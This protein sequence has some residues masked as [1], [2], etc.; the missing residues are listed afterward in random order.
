M[1]RKK[2]LWLI[3][4]LVLFWPA[5]KIEAKE[6]VSYGIDVTTLPSEIQGYLSSLTLSENNG[7]WHL[8]INN[9]LVGTKN[10]GEMLVFSY[11]PD[12]KSS[13]TLAFSLPDQLSIAYALKSTHVKTSLFVL[14]MNE[15]VQAVTFYPDS[16]NTSVYTYKETRLSGGYYDF[17]GFTGDGMNYS[18]SI[19]ASN[20]IAYV[21]R[22]GSVQ[23]YSLT[24][25]GVM[26]M[27]FLETHVPAH[28]L[29]L[30]YMSKGLTMKSFPDAKNIPYSSAEIDQAI[31]NEKLTLVNSHSGLTFDTV[32][33]QFIT[34]WKRLGKEDYDT[35]TKETIQVVCQWNEDVCESVRQTYGAGG[36]LYAVFG[37]SYSYNTISSY[38]DVSLKKVETTLYKNV[39][40]PSSNWTNSYNWPDLGTYTAVRSSTSTRSWSDYS[41]YMET[42]LTYDCSQDSECEWTSK[43]LYR[44]RTGTW[45][46]YG[47]YS[48]G[49]PS[50]CDSSSEC[51][52][53][54]KEYTSKRTASLTNNYSDFVSSCSTTDSY[55]CNLYYKYTCKKNLISSNTA[56]SAIKYSTGV[57]GPC[58]S[59]YKISKVTEGYRYRYLNWSNWS[60][61]SAT[62][63]TPV[64]G[65]T[66]C[67]SQTRYATSYLSW[68]NWSDYNQTSCSASS[69]KQ[70]QSKTMYAYRYASWSEYSPWVLTTSKTANDANK[71]TIYQKNDGV[72]TYDDNKGTSATKGIGSYYTG[73]SEVK[74]VLQEVKDYYAKENVEK[75]GLKP[76][77]NENSITA[78]GNMI[79]ENSRSSI[80]YKN[81][82]SLNG[83][84]LFEDVETFRNSFP[85]KYQTDAENAKNAFL[86]SKIFIPYIYIRD[87]YRATDR[88]MNVGGYSDSLTSVNTYSTTHSST[89]TAPLLQSVVVDNRDSRV[90]YFD[91]KNPLV[92]YSNLPK[93]WEGY[94][95]LIYEIENSDLSNYE[96]E[97]HLTED[98]LIAIRD[99]LKNGGY[100]KVGTCE[101]LRRFSYIFTQQNPQL[102]NWFV[103]SSGC[104]VGPGTP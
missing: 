80:I 58:A 16:S 27:L 61:Y 100:E 51:R 15:G 2:Q 104:K 1:L 86:N 68:S 23:S 43:N 6:S 99:Y 76:A 74:E 50:S 4:F 95:S 36:R 39:K 5:N 60:D 94:E 30:D 54:S 88:L 34:Y 73:I 96:I 83:K 53:I 31:A 82:L 70:C 91:P 69:T 49:F 9:N 10:E 26:Q 79:G 81:L 11:N 89:A 8:Y 17:G 101:L 103:S 45:S 85:A 42:N 7:Q 67:R 93:N 48:A 18:L 87:H 52:W 71:V 65:T 41:N 90:I 40:W 20:H 46:G 92:N 75:V 28:S 84:V 44:S 57:Q 38:E 14:S 21:N 97:I 98:D 66:Q 19:D 102:Q 59:G 35:S 3:L 62:S 55:R 29:D 72:F 12:L 33:R 37:D 13:F 47:S 77:M 64:T 25:G 63:C 22:D 56:Y 32:L 78:V 24:P